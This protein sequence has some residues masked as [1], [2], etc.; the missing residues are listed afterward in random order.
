[1]WDNSQNDRNQWHYYVDSEIV[2]THSLN[3][4]QQAPEM[5]GGF[6]SNGQFLAVIPVDIPFI[7]HII[8]I[9]IWTM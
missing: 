5:M 9:D 8:Q 7:L 3:R 2:V 4:C 1:M 6:I